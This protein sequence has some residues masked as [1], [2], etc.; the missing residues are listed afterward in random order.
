MISEMKQRKKKHYRKRILHKMVC[1][2]KILKLCYKK[3]IFVSGDRPDWLEETEK[4][5]KC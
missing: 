3:K 4:I 5:F 1:M 2:Y